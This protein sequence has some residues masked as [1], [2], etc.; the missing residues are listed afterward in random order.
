MIPESVE[1][2][3]KMIKK[4]IE[5]L[6]LV[7][8]S[9][10][11]GE[12]DKL[13][14]FAVNQQNNYSLTF[15]KNQLNSPTDDSSC[16]QPNPVSL[17]W[18][19]ESLRSVDGLSL[20]RKFRWVS[21]SMWSLINSCESIANLMAFLATQRNV[22]WSSSVGIVQEEILT[23]CY[24]TTHSLWLGSKTNYASDI[25]IRQLNTNYNSCGWNW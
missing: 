25:N 20:H 4:R 8:S 11:V 14:Y 3:R 2:A 21:S 22:H 23:L 10:V 12:D 1:D 7:K 19:I 9:W 13:R 6:H 5:A 24:L 18:L 17:R 15:S 16:T